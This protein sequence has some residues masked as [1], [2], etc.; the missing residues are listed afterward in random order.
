MVTASMPIFYSALLPC[1]AVSDYKQV[2]GDLSSR[3]NNSM[4]VIY[5]S[6]NKQRIF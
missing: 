6:H 4:G 3:S 5:L 2:V 1:S